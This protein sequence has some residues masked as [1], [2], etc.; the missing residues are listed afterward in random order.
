[1]DLSADD[2]VAA[3]LFQDSFRAEGEKL[4][5]VVACDATGKMLAARSGP[6]TVDDFNVLIERAT[7]RISKDQ[8]HSPGVLEL[9]V[10]PHP[11][12]TVVVTVPRDATREVRTWTS[13]Y[14][15]SVKAALLEG[16]KGVLVLQKEDGTSANALFVNLTP[17]DQRYVLGL[18]GVITNAATVAVP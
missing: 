2:P 9:G 14:S 12:N 16:S 6:G 18:K 17:E 1:M 3:K 15:S 7:G 10:P 11:T 8:A 4:P 5:C 13:I